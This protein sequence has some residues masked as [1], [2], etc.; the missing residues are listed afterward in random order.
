[1]FDW[2]SALVAPWP[3]LIG[4]TSRDR[5]Q[6]DRKQTTGSLKVPAEGLIQISLSREEV[7]QF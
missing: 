6:I 7:Q 4:G 1:M 3:S 2:H 5:R